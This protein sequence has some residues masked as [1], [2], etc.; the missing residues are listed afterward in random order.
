MDSNDKYSRRM[1][2]LPGDLL[3][4]TFTVKTPVYLNLNFEELPVNERTHELDI[5]YDGVC[6]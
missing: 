2:L 6:D 1:L 5:C 4:I 3:K